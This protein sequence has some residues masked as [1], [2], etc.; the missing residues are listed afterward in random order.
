[1]VTTLQRALQHNAAVRS[2]TGEGHAPG[3]AFSTR[4]DSLVSSTAVVVD[5]MVAT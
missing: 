3:G 1:M 5:D 4:V 2:A